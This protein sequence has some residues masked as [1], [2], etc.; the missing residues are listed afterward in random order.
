M[1]KGQPE[2]QYSQPMQ[3]SWLKSTMPLEYFT[4][5]PSA[6]QARRHPGSAQCMHW[7][8]R[9]SHD[10]SPLGASISANL[11]RFQYSACSVGKVWYEPRCSVW[12]GARSF[13]S[14]QATSQAL[15]PMQV[16]VSMYF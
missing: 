13:H 6:G 12:M 15:Q 4:I 16:E 11:I 9:I 14:A 2:T 1:L 5:A 7:S 10:R 8:L 3:F